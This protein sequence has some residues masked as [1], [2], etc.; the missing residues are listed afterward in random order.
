MKFFFSLITV[1][2]FLIGCQNTG[3]LDVLLPNE[4]ELTIQ[5]STSQAKKETSV[6]SDRCYVSAFKH[7]ETSTLSVI[8]ASIKQNDCLEQ[9]ILKESKELFNAEKQ[10][11]I[12]NILQ[13][14]RNSQDRFYDLLYNENKYCNG[15]CGLMAQVV[16]QSKV[17]EYMEQLLYD[18]LL[19]RLNKGE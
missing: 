1:M 3:E 15:K 12:K 5:E 11:E 17:T 10:Q 13:Q 14:I 9:A 18:L 16:Q 4:S 2:L 6:I 7:N 19:V 8:N